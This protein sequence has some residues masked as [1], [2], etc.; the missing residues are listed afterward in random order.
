MHAIKAVVALMG[1]LLLLGLGLLGYGL[2]VKSREIRQV[3]Q[4]G[5]TAP[6]TSERAASVPAGVL[7]FGT[8]RLDL[9][10]GAAIRQM[11]A[12]GDRIVLR[13]AAPDGEERLLVIDPARG[14][15]TG[16][17]LFPAPPE[18]DEP[19]IPTIPGR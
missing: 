19:V 17:F 14:R 6:A 4:V 9:P 15:L 18:P 1:V 7:D 10:P 12:A 16:T 2:Y 3:G 13:V 11:A 5:A 8:I